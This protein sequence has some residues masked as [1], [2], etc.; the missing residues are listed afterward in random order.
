MITGIPEIKVNTKDLY[1]LLIGNL[2]YAYTRN[3]H[4]M[5]SSAFDQT[6]RILKDMMQSYPKGATMTAKQI[7]E[8]CISLQITNNFSNGVDDEYHNLK[9]SRKFVNDLLDLIH[10]TSDDNAL[11]YPYNYDLFLKNLEL[12][13]S[14]RY[15]F[16]NSKNKIIADKVSEND[17]LNTLC[18]LAKNGSYVVSYRREKIGDNKVKFTI[19]KD[20]NSEDKIIYRELIYKA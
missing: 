6:L 15:R 5:P 17:W 9:A 7:C 13:D 3:N 12:D 1:Q 4:L 11:W 18:R 14:P 20:D 19:L 10:E 8:E 16:Y 2:R